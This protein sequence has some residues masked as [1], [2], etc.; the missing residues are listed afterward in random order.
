MIPLASSFTT[1][2][3]NPNEEDPKKVN[4]KPDEQKADQT[5]ENINAES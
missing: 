3:G 2:S 4:E 5:V 1:S